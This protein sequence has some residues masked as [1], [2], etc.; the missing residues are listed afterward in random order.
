MKALQRY[1]MSKAEE[2]A[3][4]AEIVRQV[5]ELDE[6]FSA[7][8]CAMLLWALHEEFGFGADR[9]RRVWD[10]VAVHRAELLKHYDMQDNAEFILLYK[11]RQIGVDVI[12]I[13]ALRVEGD[14]P[15]ICNS[16]RLSVFLSTPSGWRATDLFTGYPF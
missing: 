12:S 16:T 9:L 4:K 7:E 2:A 5:H 13:H 3:L 14:V 6:K 11:L 1:Q 10:C 15:S 8:I